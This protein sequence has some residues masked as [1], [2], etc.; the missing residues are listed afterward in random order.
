MSMVL[1]AL[2]QAWPH[3]SRVRPIAIL[4]AGSIVRDAHLPA[5]AKA[6][7]PVAAIF[8]RDPLRAQHL[9]DQ[10]S[11]PI[12]ARSLAQITAIEDVIFDVALPPEA[13]IEALMALPDGAAVLLQKPMG[14]DFAEARSIRDLCR[15]KK[16][17]AA[18]NL[19]LRYSPMML[20]I[21]DAERRGLFGRI[22]DIDVHLACRTPWELWPFMADLE[23]VEV[24]MHSIHY[25]DWI[26]SL[27]GTPR[28]V[29]SLS[30]AHPDHPTLRDARTT[31]ILQFD[32]PVRCALSVNHTY[33]WGP[34]HEDATILVEG[35]EGAAR[36]GLGL[37]LDYPKGQ[38]ETLEIIRQGSNWTSV[39]LS[40]R[41]FPDA[42][43]NVMANLQRHVSGEDAALGTSCESAFETMAV[44]EACKRASRAGGTP[45]PKE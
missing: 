21:A 31:T 29:Q 30:V 8:D 19:Q 24:T 45:V 42:F 26:R 5:Y 3:P 25:I 7:F 9:A 28:T 27:L 1:P 40:G 13:M 4:G 17:V 6:G 10:Y 12:V 39:P 16:L 20:A 35:T 18:V 37:L 11:I 34:R 14:R 32:A 33:R 38:P 22:V 15:A 44:V 2:A 23:A 41:W 36:V 43:A